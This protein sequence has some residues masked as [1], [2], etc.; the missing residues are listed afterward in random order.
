MRSRDKKE[1]EID[2]ALRVVA[3]GLMC[4]WRPVGFLRVW[5]WGNSLVGD[6]GLRAPSASLVVPH[7]EC[8]GCH[9]GG[10]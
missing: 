5:Y 1:A 9:T 8:S 7:T 3:N 2:V 4:K 10:Q 6:D